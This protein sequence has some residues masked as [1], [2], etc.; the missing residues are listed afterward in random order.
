MITGTDL[1]GQGIPHLDSFGN[2]MNDTEH[3]AHFL[4][5]NDVGGA[6]GNDFADSDAGDRLGLA[7]RTSAS[8]PLAFEPSLN[9]IGSSQEGRPDMS[10]VASFDT[11]RWLIDGGALDNSPFG[12]VLDIVLGLPADRQVRRVVA[13]VVPYSATLPEHRDPGK[14]PAMSRVMSA[15][16]NLP[17]DL[18]LSNDLI[19][20]EEYR[21]RRRARIGIRDTLLRLGDDTLRPIAT[22]LFSVSRSS[23]RICRSTRCSTGCCPGTR[24]PRRI[25]RHGTPTVCTCESTRSRPTSSLPAAPPPT[26]PARPCHDATRGHARSRAQTRRRRS[27]CPGFQQRTRL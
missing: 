25:P 11:S 4:F 20:I 19:R 23:G 18:S 7:A 15:A 10:P 5:T 1:V 24:R 13:Y 6:G 27:C 14:M 17:R 8:F 12:S 2:C 16:L 9:L 21:R 3:R 22:E 26:A